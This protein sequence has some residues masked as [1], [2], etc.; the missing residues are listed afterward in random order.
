MALNTPA[1][2]QRAA[3]R[4]DGRESGPSTGSGGER[5]VS[6]RSRAGDAAGPH[7]DG[8]ACVPSLTA[9][10]SKAGKRSG[11]VLTAER[12]TEIACARNAA[13]WSN[14]CHQ[15]DGYGMPKAEQNGQ[16]AR[17]ERI[18][19]H[20]DLPVG[21]TN[22]DGSMVF[23]T[24]TRDSLGGGMWSA[25]VWRVVT[26]DRLLPGTYAS[27]GSALRAARRAELSVVEVEHG[28][29]RSEAS[30]ADQPQHADN[31]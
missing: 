12:I 8:S 6:G 24:F 22:T 15:R 23:R 20:K 19:K 25:F 2:R 30:E 4:L 14:G 3:T 18:R 31:S 11:T 7:S 9:A 5:G 17:R 10:A 26:G 13:L 28:L 27:K 1:N 29:H 21:W 16:T